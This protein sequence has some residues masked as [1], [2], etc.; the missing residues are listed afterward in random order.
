MPR[1]RKP[2]P[3]AI[4]ELEGAFKNQP[5]RKNWLE[6]PAPKE[7]PEPPRGLSKEANVEWEYITQVLEEM[8]VLS[9]CDRAALEMYC[10]T[11][12]EYKKAERMVAKQGAVIDV[13]DH[14]GNATPRRN[15]WDIIRRDNLGICHKLLIEFGLTPSSRS[16][17]KQNKSAADIIKINPRS[18][19]EN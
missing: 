14:K 6:P 8:N 17:V 15:P 9:R 7:K 5:G 10:R 3:T 2:K 13:V 1:G 18:R 19:S 11:W 12:A 4:R 16:R